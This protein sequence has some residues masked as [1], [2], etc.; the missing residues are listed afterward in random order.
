MTFDVWKQS[1]LQ[2]GLDKLKTVSLP[3][4]Q[5]DN[6]EDI[7]R[8]AGINNVEKLANEMNMSYTGTE[9]ARLMKKHNIQPGTPEWFQLWFSLPKL[10]GEKPVDK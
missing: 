3:D 9:K 6:L 10:T 2:N 4:H 5:S 8:L 7:K 1:K